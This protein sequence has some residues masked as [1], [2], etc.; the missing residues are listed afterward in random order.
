MQASD[1]KQ[2]LSH[3]YYN[4]VQPEAMVEQNV[5]PRSRVAGAEFEFAELTLPDGSNRLIIIC[6]TTVGNGP[7]Q[8]FKA[9]AA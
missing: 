8:K 5:I 4:N 9:T 7:G 2:N 6:P 1:I 3:G